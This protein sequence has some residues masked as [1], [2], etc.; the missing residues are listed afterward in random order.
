MSLHKDEIEATNLLMLEALNTCLAIQDI[1]GLEDLVVKM[2]GALN[3]LDE[4]R[5]KNA[6]RTVLL[7]NLEAAALYYAAEAGADPESLTTL[8]DRAIDL[9]NYDSTIHPPKP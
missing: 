6:E 2:R 5:K 8:F 3:S 4:I 7:S 9:Y 1:D